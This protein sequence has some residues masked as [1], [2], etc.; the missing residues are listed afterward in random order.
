MKQLDIIVSPLAFVWNT[1]LFLAHVTF[2]LD[3]V[4][5]GG[6]SHIFSRY[7]F[8]SSESFSIDFWPSDRQMGRQKVMH[9]SSPCISTGGLKNWIST[10]LHILLFITTCTKCNN[11]L[12]NSTNWCKDGMLPLFECIDP[13][14]QNHVFTL[15]RTVPF[16][17]KNI[18]HAST[19]LQF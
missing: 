6:H 4:T 7:D 18:W 16:L 10:Y 1:Y 8:F 15:Y 17:C 14:Q 13:A 11:I 5:L 12:Q 9:K 2:D 19:K 3:H